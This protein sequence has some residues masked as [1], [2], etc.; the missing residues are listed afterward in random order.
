MSSSDRRASRSSL[1]PSRVTCSWRSGQLAATLPAPDAPAQEPLG[2][3]PLER[4]IERAARHVALEQALQ[5]APH[6]HRTRL[7]TTSQRGE[8][9]TLL[10][11]AQV[12]SAHKSTE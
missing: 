5:L 2:F 11:F 12:E 8:K 7:V 4:G 3:E 1:I 9:D 10:E 6:V